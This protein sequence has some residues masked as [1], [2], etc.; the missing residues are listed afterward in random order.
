MS[1]EAQAWRRP[2]PRE[3]GRAAALACFG[4]LLASYAVNAMDRQLFPLL[5]PEVRSEYG[6]S[7]AAIGL[8]STVFTL[9]M[10][11]AGLPTSYL[12]ARFSR[13]TVLQAGIALFSA[14]TALTAIS[15]GFAD[16]LA[17]RAVTG[18]GEAMQLTILLAI[19]AHSFVRYRA[20]AVGAINFF[21]ALGAII[22]PMLGGV[23]LN[24]SGSWR[25]PMVIYGAIGFV[26]IAVIAIGVRPWFS[27]MERPAQD[28]ID[29]D[30]AASIL[31]RNTVL[32]TV[33]SLIGGLVIYGYLGMYPT[34]LREGLNYTPAAA[35]TVMGIY[36]MGA[37]AS[38]AGGWLGDRYPP[39]PVLAT[40]FVLA[41]VLGHLLF[42]G[43]A[44]FL[45]QAILSFLWGVV[46]S[47][48]VYVNLAGYH[49]KAL[50]SQ[51]A[52]HASGMFVTSL[53]GSA[54]AAG[55]LM[56]WIAGRAGWA[57]A[58][59]IQITALSLAAGGIALGLKFPR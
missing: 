4:V 27:E 29:R 5:A 17:Y 57:A 22:G 36:G 15:V 9:G 3:E 20:A 58:G 6:F 37:L 54:A 59:E 24:A 10:A 18:I 39:R 30:G 28:W 25:V 41:A 51:L 56:G 42:N 8:L 33:M 32:L 2:R 46:V 38:I 31:N 11:V 21:F 48:V 40:S 23:L 35:G 45:A 1:S 47:G 7:L 49:V 50:R 14:G 44:A 12:L 55:Y 34:F 52:G 53:Y 16:M 26:A 19:A 13:K 43:P